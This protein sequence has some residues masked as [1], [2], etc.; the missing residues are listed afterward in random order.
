M[1]IIKNKIYTPDLFYIEVTNVFW[2]Y[3]RQNLY[4][5]NEVE[6]NLTILKDFVLR[7]VSTT[8]LIKSAFQIADE[9]NISAYDGAYIALSLEVNAPLLTCDRR[10]INSL[11]T[12]PD[13]VQFFPDTDIIR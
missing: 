6:R 12:S 9:Y 11:T 1:R 7:V 8:E 10:L 4:S 2:K 5:V 3:V 13:N